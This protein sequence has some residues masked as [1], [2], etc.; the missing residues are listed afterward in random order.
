MSVTRIWLGVVGILGAAGAIDSGRTIDEWWPV[1]VIG[2][3][4]ARALNARNVSIGSAVVAALGVALLGDAQQWAAD[5]VVWPILISLAGIA[6]LLAGEGRSTR[7]RC[8]LGRRPV[9]R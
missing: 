5:A 4:A 3:A 8:C 1:A 2:W 9:V 6:I 7:G